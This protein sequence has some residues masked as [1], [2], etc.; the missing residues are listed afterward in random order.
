MSLGRNLEV[1]EG[2][3]GKSPVR[4]LGE[5]VPQKLKHFDICETL[6]V[7]HNL[8]LYVLGRFTSDPKLIFWSSV[9]TAMSS[10]KEKGGVKFLQTPHK[11]S[12]GGR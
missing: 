6:Y 12:P 9:G 8:H 4:T 2:V 5:K 3:Q 1:P 11:S 7:V 10:G